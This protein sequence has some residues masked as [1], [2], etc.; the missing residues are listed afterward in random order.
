MEEDN[1]AFF[2]YMNFDGVYIPLPDCYEVDISEKEADSGGKTEAGRIQR[3]VV[4]L[5]LSSYLFPFLLPRSG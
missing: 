3:D 1:N 4:K 5:A 2:Q